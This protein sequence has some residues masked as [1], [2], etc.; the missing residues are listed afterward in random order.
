[1]LT[2]VANTGE[3]FFDIGFL[4]GFEVEYH[5]RSMKTEGFI[6]RKK[7]HHFKQID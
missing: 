1:M 2:D 5:N 3:T 4:E 7:E 6:Q